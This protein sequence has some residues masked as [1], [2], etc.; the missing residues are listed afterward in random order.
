[1]DSMLNTSKNRGDITLHNDGE[2]PHVLLSPFE[3]LIVAHLL[4]G[5]IKKK[6]A[7]G[8]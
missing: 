4:E 7:A 2:Q 6:E 5:L 1:M 8:M 3:S